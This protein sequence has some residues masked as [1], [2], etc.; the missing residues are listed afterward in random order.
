[1]GGFLMKVVILKECPICDS[2]EWENWDK[3][4]DHEY[5]FNLDWVYDEPIGFKVCKNCGFVTYD[6]RDNVELREHYDN[7]R[8]LMQASAI[9]TCNR[10]NEYH[11]AFL[12]DILK[13]DFRIMDLGCAQGSFL[14]MLHKEYDI[15]L[16]NLYGTEWSQGFKAFGK[17]E[18]NLNITGDIADIKIKQKPD[19]YDMI[20]YYHVLEHIQY[21]DK[22]LEKIKG[23]LKDDGYVYIAI[24]VWFDVLAEPSGMPT[25]EFENLYHMNHVNVFTYQSFRNLLNKCN[26]DI[27]KEN[28]TYYGYTVLCKKKELKRDLIKE[29]HKKLEEDLKKQKEAISYISAPMPDKRE[30]EKAYKVYPK[31]PEAYMYHVL[32]KDNMKDFKKTIEILDKGLKIIPD[33][34]KLLSQLAIAY[35]QWDENKPDKKIFFSNNLK[36]AEKKLN[37][38][39]ELKPADEQAYYFLGMIEGKYKGN[40]DKAVENFKKM[41]KINPIKFAEV[42]N[43]VSKF[44]KE[45]LIKEQEDKTK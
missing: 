4:R 6:Y 39:L 13:P 44:Y 2:S 14:N 12:D 30:P 26:L 28:T 19:K 40:Y 45:K 43:L 5:W 17:Y 10:K 27:V 23:Y 16:K 7:E 20:C 31:F 36:Q 15:P 29:D 34:H 21:P 11:K 9:I 1:M 8:I 3:H 18:Y 42:Y 33:N 37:K 24:P 32:N 35:L 41:L 38:C 22:E 25:V